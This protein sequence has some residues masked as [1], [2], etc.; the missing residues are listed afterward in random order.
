MYGLEF[1]KAGFHYGQSRSRSGGYKKAYD[2][3]KIEI[4][5]LSAVISSTESES[6]ESERFHF[7]DSVYI[8]IT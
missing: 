5:V 3:V 4:G 2:L 6:G 1:V 7:S 8:S